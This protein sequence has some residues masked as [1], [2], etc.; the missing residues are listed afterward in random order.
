MK[1]P[2]VR[3]GHGKSLIT[4]NILTVDW[5]HAGGAERKG[6]PLTAKHRSETRLATRWLVTSQ[7]DTEAWGTSKGVWK[8]QGI[9]N[10]EIVII[11]ARHSLPLIL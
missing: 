7:T 10:V 8:L 9:L 6:S 2:L 11:L 1:N 3:S 4:K 5:T